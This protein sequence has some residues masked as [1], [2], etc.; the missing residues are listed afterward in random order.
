MMKNYVTG[1]EY[2]GQNEAILA[3]CGVESVLTFKQAIKLKGLS[4]KK[5][6]GLKKCATLI[7]YKTAENEEGKKEKKPFFFSV[8]DSEAVLARAA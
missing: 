3:E 7:G 6:K 1:Y 2:T 4:G 8:F 5:L